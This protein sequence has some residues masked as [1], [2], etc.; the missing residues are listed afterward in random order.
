MQPSDPNSENGLSQ[1]GQEARI[2]H[3]LIPDGNPIRTEAAEQVIRDARDFI[4]ARRVQAKR[5]SAVD[6][7]REAGL[8]TSLGT[9]ISASLLSQIFAGCYEGDTDRYLRQ[10]DAFLAAQAERAERFDTSGF[11]HVGV[12]EKIF[13][14]IRAAKRN[15]SMGLVVMEPGEGK[16]TIAMAYAASDPHAVLVRIEERAGTAKAVIDAVHRGLASREPVHGYNQ[17]R[18]VIRVRMTG[19]RSMIVLV[20]EAQKLQRSGLEMLRDLHDASDPTGQ[21]PVPIVLFGDHGFL[22]LL[23]RSRHGEATMIRPQL[24]RRI[25]PVFDSHSA[26]AGLTNDPDKLYTLA[27][28]VSILRN[29]RLRLITDDATRWLWGVSNCRGWG[30]LGLV[31]A[32]VRLAHDVAGDKPIGVPEL[33][34][35]LRLVI[36]PSEAA[37]VDD[38]ARA[39]LLTERAGVA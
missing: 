2:D 24:T 19:N 13:G 10:I 26:E 25:Y 16:S 31:M 12:A 39:V 4:L 38:Q 21:Y 17:K 15:N 6:F 30:A 28:I 20:D 29:R 37:I 36:G 32:I 14:V 27:D 5:Y 3:R 11:V 9:P 34:T 18:E 33:R 23:V 35:A 22:R 1:L 7:A 8:V